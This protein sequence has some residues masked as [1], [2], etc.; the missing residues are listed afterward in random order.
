M[1]D[2]RAQLKKKG[3]LRSTRDKYVDIVSAVP[4][5][6][7]PLDWV[8][9]KV[10]S[11]TPLGTVLPMRAAVKHYLM[12]EQG[13][14]SAELDEL[15]PPAEGYAAKA[16]M[17]LTGAQLATYFVAVAEIQ[18]E[19]AR[20]IL[21]LLPK[22]GLRI[23]E[24]C[25]LQ[26]SDYNGDS[27]QFTGTRGE[28]HVPLD[29]AARTTMARYQAPDGKWLFMGYSGGPIG[30]HAVRKYTRK[31]G[32]LYPDLVAVSPDVL[33]SSFAVRS[34]RN[35]MHIKVLQNIL[36]HTT[37]VTTQRYLRLVELGS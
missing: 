33:R 35:G 18:A 27:F 17:P 13:Y 34:L 21:E 19:P 11:E 24:I 8:H 14:S 10:N 37:P 28:R 32:E 1:S 29:S 22:T 30:P 9:A 20:T 26:K 15:L 4:E 3:L 5:G 6:M 7:H 12:T 16:R 36:G 2:F 25:A 23:S 31:I